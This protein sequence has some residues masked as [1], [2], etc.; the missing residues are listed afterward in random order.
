MTSPATA[1]ALAREDYVRRVHLYRAVLNAVE[2]GAAKAVRSAALPTGQGTTPV[3]MAWLAQNAKKPG[4]ITLPSGLQYVVNSVG[5]AGRGSPSPKLTSEVDVKWRT[6]LIDGTEVDPLAQRRVQPRSTIHGFSLALQLMGEGDKWTLYLPAELAYGDAGRAELPD[7]GGA[8]VPPRAALI[9]DVELMKV[10]GSSKPKPLRPP[11]PPRPGG[12]F[13]PAPSFEGGNCPGFIFTTRELGTGYYLDQTPSAGAHSPTKA[14][15]HASLGAT[16]APP[17]AAASADAPGAVSAALASV[18]EAVEEVEEEDVPVTLP[19]FGPSCPPEKMPPLP[20][21]PL[22]P[23]APQ[24]PQQSQRQ[25]QQSQ[26]QPPQ[27]Q[28]RKQQP[29]SERAPGAAVAAAAAA[30][31]SATSAPS[32]AKP[33]S[34]TE[35]PAIT[36]RGASPTRGPIL[37]P[38]A[39]SGGKNGS[40]CVGERS[41][42]ARGGSKG[43]GS[44]AFTG[45]GGGGAID[46]IVKGVKSD[47]YSHTYSGASSTYTGATSSI[48]ALSTAASSTTPSEA[49][50]RGPPSISGTITSTSTGAG[51]PRNG[52][53]DGASR[54]GTAAM[55][56][57]LT[58]EYTSGASPTLMKGVSPNPNPNPNPNFERTP[59]SR[60]RPQQS[61]VSAS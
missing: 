20:P 24:Q 33:S 47:E 1:A 28:P 6:T 49:S 13:I 42:T 50:W 18:P 51:A 39:R 56:R 43:G 4:V 41:P 44:D 36:R 58:E 11:D 52:A 35:T 38:L 46:S 21:P 57:R 61:E 16:A 31:T 12:T 54:T 32:P 23:Q 8:A 17:P 19:V 3:G 53:Q 26:R 48:G 7:G 30:A 25:P 15:A 27:Q 40:G 9:L 29:A 10:V 55:M 2:D 22:P 37:T 5:G 59:T 34:G 14:A 45:K 60:P